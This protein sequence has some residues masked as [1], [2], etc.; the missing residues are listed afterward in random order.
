MVNG[1]E[2]KR[3]TCSIYE[4]IIN[5]VYSFVILGPENLKIEVIDPILNNGCK[6]WVTA[7]MAIKVTGEKN[8][9]AVHITNNTFQITKKFR[10]FSKF[11]LKQAGAELGQAQPSWAKM[12][13][14]GL[15]R[16]QY[17]VQKDICHK[18]IIGQLCFRQRCCSLIRNTNMRLVGSNRDW[19][20]PLSDRVKVQRYFGLEH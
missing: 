16:C 12:L 17:L 8:I 14:V 15:E 18:L 11:V 1:W 7:E 4:G 5:C 10:Q 2:C 6:I 13:W 9:C 3:V 20:V 19:L